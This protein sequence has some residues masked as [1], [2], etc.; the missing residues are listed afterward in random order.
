MR[1]DVGLIGAT[2]IAAR[3]VVAPSRDVPDVHVAAVAASDLDR[4][5]SFADQHG[6]PCAHRDY[7]A[8]VD[9]PDVNVVYVSLHNSAHHRWAV[10]AASAGKH[11]LVEKPMGV[12]VEES[13]DLCDAARTTGLVVQVGDEV[14]DGSVA[15]RLE[16]ARRHLPS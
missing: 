13:E 7:A 2:G 6:I 14:I 10:A 12:T 9:D 8:L 15:G 16:A 1:L 4:A 3:A 11:V 5:R